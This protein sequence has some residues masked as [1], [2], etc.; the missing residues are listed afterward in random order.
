MQDKED[1]IMS[2]QHFHGG[3][4]GCTNGLKKCPG[5]QFFDAKWSLPDLNDAHE[6]HNKKLDNLRGKALLLNYR[7]KKS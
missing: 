3:C 2:R 5:C 1:K 4:M 7:D 6:R